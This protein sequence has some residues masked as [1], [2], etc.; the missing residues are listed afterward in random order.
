MKN[1]NREKDHFSSSDCYMERRFEDGYEC[2]CSY[3]NNGVPEVKKHGGKG[4]PS[5]LATMF[6]TGAPE[7]AQHE[8][9]GVPSLLATMFET[10]EG[11]K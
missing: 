1:D 11:N 3:P 7:V 4:V 10:G 2:D 8:G 5:L 9:K 6:E